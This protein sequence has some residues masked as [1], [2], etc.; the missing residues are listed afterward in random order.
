MDSSFRLN[1][2]SGDGV[3]KR[4]KRSCSEA[5]NLITGFG[6]ERLELS[7]TISFDWWWDS[8]DV[9]LT[10]ERTLHWHQSSK[11]FFNVIFALYIFGSRDLELCI[12]SLWIQVSVFNWDT[13]KLT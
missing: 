4:E 13:I 10:R 7:F 6:A 9:I 1:A 3:P 11:S 8:V 2:C 5:I 12:D